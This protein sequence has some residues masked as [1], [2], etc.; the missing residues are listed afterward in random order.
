M[1]SRLCKCDWRLFVHAMEEIQAS[2]IETS[3]TRSGL[4]IVQVRSS[5]PIS[6]VIMAVVHQ[7][8]RGASVVSTLASI[9]HVG[10]TDGLQ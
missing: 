8:P 4:S 6:G 9:V 1:L 7:S 10:A 2:F 3:L 5:Q